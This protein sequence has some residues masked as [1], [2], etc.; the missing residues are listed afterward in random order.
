MGGNRTM[1]ILHILER[2]FN[3]MEY[4]KFKMGSTVSVAKCYIDDEVSEPHRSEMSETATV[5]SEPS[6]NEELVSIQY[7]S[8]LIDYVPQDILE[9][10]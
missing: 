4:K 9:I 2:K 10:V 5:C 1:A 3:N 6:D 8:G 7:E